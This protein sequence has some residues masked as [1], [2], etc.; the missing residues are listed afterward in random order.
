MRSLALGLVVF[1]VHM[2]S[3]FFS[4][5]FPKMQEVE[6][7]Y[8]LS[9]TCE[10]PRQ[11]PGVQEGLAPNRSSSERERERER[12][13]LR[14][15]AKMIADFAKLPFP[16]C[17]EC[18]TTNAIVYSKDGTDCFYCRGCWE[19]FLAKHGKLWEGTESR[20][21]MAN[22]RSCKTCLCEGLFMFV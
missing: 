7:R 5:H 16:H 2:S 10:S 6:S 15:Q 4:L 9:G 22:P 11:D 17:W 19:R 13:L 14:R 8:V 18:G 3:K 21:L 12:A 20:L 1:I